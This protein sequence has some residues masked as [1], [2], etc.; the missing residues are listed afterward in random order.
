MRLAALMPARALRAIDRVRTRRFLAVTGPATR[1]Y[2]RRYGLRVRHGPFSGMTY[3]KGLEA[4]SGDLVAKLTGTYERELHRAVTDWIASSLDYVIDVG[5]AEGYYAIGFAL[6]IPQAKIYAFDIDPIARERC[7]AMSELNGVRE[8]VEIKGMCDPGSLGTFPEHGV[9]VFSDCEGAE[10]TL[11]DPILAPCLRSWPIIVELHDFFDPTIS[12]TIC[13]R[14]APTHE[15]ELIEGEAR[16]HDIPVEL[17]FTT[18]RQRAA[19]LSEHRPGP[20]RWAHLRPRA[21]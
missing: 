13:Q 2:V 14:F 7:A 16:E 6:G 17:S 18:K 20:M 11:L 3:L 19:L 1:E 12:S 21:P 4:T 5:S 10:R 8:R 15:I 9:A